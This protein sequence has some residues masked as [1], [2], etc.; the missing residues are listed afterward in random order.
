[1]DAHHVP[2]TV[3]HFAFYDSTLTHTE[4]FRS[5]LLPFFPK[6]VPASCFESGVLFPLVRF[7][8]YFSG[9][10]IPFGRSCTFQATMSFNVTIVTKKLPVSRISK[11]MEFSQNDMEIYVLEK[12]HLSLY[13]ATYFCGNLWYIIGERGNTYAVDYGRTV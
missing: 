7:M 3:S 1:M 8:R 12:L 4:H 9:K 2:F 6:A 13:F 11:R 10:H 5:G